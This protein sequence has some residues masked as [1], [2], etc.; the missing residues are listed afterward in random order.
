M[1]PNF[2]I[3]KWQ[4]DSLFQENIKAHQSNKLCQKGSCNSKFVW[5]T[6]S[7]L[8][9]TLSCVLTHCHSDILD[10]VKP[11]CHLKALELGGWLTIQSHG[12]KPVFLPIPDVEDLRSYSTLFPVLRH[13]SALQLSILWFFYPL[14]NDSLIFLWSWWRL[15]ESQFY[16]PL[17]LSFSWGIDSVSLESLN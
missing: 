4:W 15:V 1:S 14:A 3:Q 6:G 8:P 2:I 5:P 17:Q 9:T 16:I 13:H 7:F 11:F 12:I 10:F